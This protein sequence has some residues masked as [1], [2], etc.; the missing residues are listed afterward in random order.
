MKLRKVSV[1]ETLDRCLTQLEEGQATIEDCLAAAPALA[2]ELR[3][4]LEAALLA[5]AERPHFAPRAA[6]A[7]TSEARVLNRLGLRRS[8]PAAARGPERR[9]WLALVPRRLAPVLLT[10]ALVA[11]LGLGGLGVVR[12]SA[13]ALPG[14]QL[15]S[16]KRGIEEAQL[17]LTFDPESEVR[18]LGSLAD[19]RLQEIEVL[20]E[21]NRL[22]DLEAALR[23]YTAAVG[24]LARASLDL[25]A[26][27]PEEVVGKLTRHIAV[28]EEVQSRVPEAAQRAIE[29]AIERS[30]EAET[31]ELPGHSG[32]QAPDCPPGLGADC[33]S[34]TG[35]SRNLQMADQIA[36]I[37]NV[38]PAEALAVY[39]G[40]CQEDWKCV[41]AYFK[42]LGRQRDR[43]NGN[44]HKK[45]HP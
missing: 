35:D 13:A 25:G 45:P 16:L 14:D 21:S 1:E 30:I 40:Q 9:P 23:G 32:P 10:A 2:D 42:D 34:E 12:V 11:A 41:R 36:N 27:G 38:S 4:L 6:F 39:S 20:T 37:Y 24:R 28:L 19:E 3:P 44:D 29:R 8:D 15:Y 31:E 18:L 5:R 7:Q 17:V 43:G 33:P 22:E 26:S